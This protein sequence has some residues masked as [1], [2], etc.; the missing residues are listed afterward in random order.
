MIAKGHEGSFSNH[1]YFNM[2][3]DDAQFCECSKMH[4]IIYFK[5]VNDVVCEV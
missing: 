2:D 1:E 5:W 4:G 3:C